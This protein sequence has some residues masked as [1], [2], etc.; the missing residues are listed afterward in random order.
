MS[1]IEIFTGPGCTHCDAAKRFL[2]AHGLDYV[3]RDVSDPEVLSELQT[4]LPRARALPQI[5]EDGAHLGNDQDLREHLGP[6]PG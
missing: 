2:Q 1:E 3:E 4:R 5:F 6:A